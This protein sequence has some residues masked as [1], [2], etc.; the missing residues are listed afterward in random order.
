LLLV[1]P[2]R[3]EATIKYFFTLNAGNPNQV[4]MADGIIAGLMGTLNVQF[5]ILKKSMVGVVRGGL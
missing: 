1:G 3:G 5:T 4:T 2:E